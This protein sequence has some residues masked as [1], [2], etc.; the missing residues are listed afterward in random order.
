VATETAVKCVACTCGQAADAA[1]PAA[2]CTGDCKANCCKA[3]A[4]KC[5]SCKADAAKGG[6]CKAGADGKTCGAAT[7]KCC[8]YALPAAEAKADAPAK[9]AK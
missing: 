8:G 4:D 7:G 3:Q 9:D 6:T 1:K 5:A 2:K